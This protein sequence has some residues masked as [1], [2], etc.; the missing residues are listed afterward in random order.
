MSR[1]T[2]IFKHYKDFLPTIDAGNFPSKSAWGSFFMTI[3]NP[4]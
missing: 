2:C 1:I 3:T 4:L